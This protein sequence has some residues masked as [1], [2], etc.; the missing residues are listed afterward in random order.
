[1]VTNRLIVRLMNVE[2]Y[3]RCLETFRATET[4]GHRPACAKVPVNI[5]QFINEV[6]TVKRMLS[7]WENEFPILSDLFTWEVP[8]TTFEFV[9]DKGLHKNLKGH[10]QSYRIHNEM[11]IR[12]KS[13]G[14]LCDEADVEWDKRIAQVM[15]CAGG[16]SSTAYQIIRFS[17]LRV[18]LYVLQQGLQIQSTIHLR[19]PPTVLAVLGY[20]V[21]NRTIGVLD[22]RDIT[23]WSGN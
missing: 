14:K 9:L 11:D 21:C 22:L 13:D 17:H 18:P 12:E 16:L 1:M 23:P 5:K 8:P 3:P 19:C 2:V 15:S 6:Y 10:L 20:T 4:I 7:V